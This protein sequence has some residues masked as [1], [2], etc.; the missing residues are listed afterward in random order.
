MNH[1]HKT[2][3]AG[4]NARILSSNTS[5]YSPQIFEHSISAMRIFCSMYIVG[6]TPGL[7]PSED[8]G[9]AGRT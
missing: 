3:T 2:H 4:Y 7:I 9:R 6:H 5:Q 8:D 1:W